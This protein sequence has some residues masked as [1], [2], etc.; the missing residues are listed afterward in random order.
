MFNYRLTMKSEVMEKLN[1]F[2]SVIRTMASRSCEVTTEKKRLTEIRDNVEN[3]EEE[4]KN[5]ISELAKLEKDWKAESK[6]YNLKLYGGKDDKGNKIGGYCD[7]I[8]KDFYKSYCTYILECKDSQFKKAVKDFLVE[9][10]VNDDVRERAVEEFTKA[11][12]IILG[13]R[14][15]SN[16]KIADGE[17]FI[18]TM[19]KRSFKKVLFGAILDIIAKSTIKV[20][21]DN[22]AE[23]DNK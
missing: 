5:A 7:N 2:E 1:N 20:E 11:L 12:L 21:D 10:S 9:N 13:G 23:D 4:I 22:K 3:S 17:K 16:R 18:A 8:S 6:A 19:N 15:N 14:F